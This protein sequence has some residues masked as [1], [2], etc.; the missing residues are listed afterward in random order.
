MAVRELVGEGDL[1][2][3]TLAGRRSLPEKK[4]SVSHF[5]CDRSAARE[6]SRSAVN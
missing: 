2:T 3:V 5:R 4:G 6:I 1:K